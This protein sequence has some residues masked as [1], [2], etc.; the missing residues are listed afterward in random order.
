MFDQKDTFTPPFGYVSSL[1]HRLTTGNSPF[2]FHNEIEIVYHHSGKGRTEIEK[3]EIYEFTPGSVNVYLPEIKH[4]QPMTEPGED[5]CLIVKK[6]TPGV[7]FSGKS[8][9]LE[10]I[11]DEYIIQELESL[12]NMCLIQ[13]EEQQILDL[14]VSALLSALSLEWK[15]TGSEQNISQAEWYALEARRICKDIA[16]FR[17]VSEIAAKLNISTDYLRHIFHTK[18]GCSLKSYIDSQRIKRAC[19]LLRLSNMPLKLIAGQCGFSN[20]S[21]FCTAFKKATGMSPGQFRSS[22]RSLT[23]TIRIP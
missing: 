17:A 1:R 19:E 2:H 22:N 8:F 16:N 3:G 20:E 9:F 7:E 11:R 23:T 14:R 10:K 21:Y 15:R 4:N 13:G 18:F 5:Y 12:T 6:Q